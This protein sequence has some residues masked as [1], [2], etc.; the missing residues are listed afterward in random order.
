VSVNSNSRNKGTSARCSQTQGSILSVHSSLQSK[1]LS[2]S[3]SSGRQLQPQQRPCHAQH[4]GSHVEVIS[5]SKPGA[6]EHRP[7]SQ[8]QFP[9]GSS[10]RS[11][12]S[13]LPRKLQQ[14]KC[15]VP[16]PLWQPGQLEQPSIEVINVLERGFEPCTKCE[17]KVYFEFIMKPWFTETHKKQL[18]Y[19]E[20]AKA[21]KLI[22]EHYLNSHLQV[23]PNDLTPCRMEQGTRCYSCSLCPYQTFPMDEIAQRK[24]AKWE[25]ALNSLVRHY[26]LFHDSPA[27]KTNIRN[28]FPNPF[29]PPPFSASTTSNFRH[30][31]SEPDSLSILPNVDSS[32]EEDTLD[33][34]NWE[35][36]IDFQMN[37][38]EQMDLCAQDPLSL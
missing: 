11:N 37:V 26:K 24:K 34:G 33:A 8:N 12:Q 1:V 29:Q 27:S 4:K 28:N 10:H 14:K 2:P 25:S 3:C 19:Q 13:N 16:A 35:P 5:L 17:Y 21:R 6:S 7:R 32:L 31:P 23:G 22:N 36:E 15:A 9:V 20:R 38:D 18:R 30:T